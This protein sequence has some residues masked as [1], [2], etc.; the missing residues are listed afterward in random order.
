MFPKT[1]FDATIEDNI[2]FSV[3]N[4]THEQVIK[5]AKQANAHDFIMEFPEGMFF[6][7]FA[8]LFWYAISYT[9]CF[10][11]YNTSVGEGSTLISGGQKQR[12][13]IA[14]ALLKTPSVLLL[15]KSTYHEF[16]SFCFLEHCPC[17]CSQIE[18][19]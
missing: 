19:R 7:R 11:G 10:K 1:L 16:H 2:R 8:S 18:N 5:A 12:I 4:A 3:P 6:S 14:R 13:A 17:D 15:G 9:S